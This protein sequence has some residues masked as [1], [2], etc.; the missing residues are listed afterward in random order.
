MTISPFAA[1]GFCLVSGGLILFFIRMYRQRKWVKTKA[2]VTGYGPPPTRKGMEY[3]PPNERYA[4][5]ET[6]PHNFPIVFF[7]TSTG[8]KVSLCKES[9]DFSSEVVGR[10]F[11]I[12]YDPENPLSICSR[13]FV[14][15]FPIELTVFLI[16]IFL[17]GTDLAINKR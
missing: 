12:L 6:S 2:K 1:F 11:W 8:E 13:R 3:L 9:F 16:G 4:H 15:R 10:E 14:R 7:E 17:V 5:N